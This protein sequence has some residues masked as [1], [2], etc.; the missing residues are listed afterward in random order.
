MNISY[1]SVTFATGG[2]RY[3]RV[4]GRVYG[5]GK[6]TPDGFERH[7]HCPDC[8]FDHSTLMESASPTVVHGNT[9]G[10]WQH[11]SIPSTAG[12][13]ATLQ[14]PQLSEKT[15][16]VMLRPWTPTPQLMD[17]GM[18]KIVWLAARLAATGPTG[19][20]RTRLN[21]LTTASSS[22]SARTKHEQMKTCTS[23]TSR[24]MSSEEK[25][26]TSLLL[27]TVELVW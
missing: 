27:G 24:Y 25:S 5:Y 10:V 19:S 3:S 26:R 13:P 20:A 14:S 15:T 7:T 12:V 18:E 11:Q 16:S 4:C 23:N 6:G 17:S 2:V 1:S 21:L 9:S 22:G 8:T